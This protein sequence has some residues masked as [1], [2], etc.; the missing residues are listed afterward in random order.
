[1]KIKPNFVFVFLLAFL[2]SVNVNA[3]TATQA[4]SDV[5]TF[6]NTP[7]QGGFSR[8]VD[9]LVSVT[10]KDK[11]RTVGGNIIKQTSGVFDNSQNGTLKTVKFTNFQSNPTNFN[12]IANVSLK[13]T[14]TS[15]G[16]IEFVNSP[17]LGGI[18]SESF[19]IA[20][21]FTA[22]V[23]ENTPFKKYI[24]FGSFKGKQITIALNPTETQI[25]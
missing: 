6:L 19:T 23:T 12:Q 4:V 5:I 2:F 8:R 1:M 16:T 17:N 20:S 11:I 15:L 7:G 10:E 21:G 13:V 22:I 3:Q 18:A 24:L 14:A 25:N 9:Y